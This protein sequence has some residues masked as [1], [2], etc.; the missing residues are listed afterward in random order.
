MKSIGYR[1][2]TPVTYGL[3]EEARPYA[4]GAVPYTYGLDSSSFMR[5]CDCCS[6]F[7][8]DQISN[9]FKE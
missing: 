4:Y 7:V 2:Y 6:D 3:G 5:F 8:S 9:D 1:P